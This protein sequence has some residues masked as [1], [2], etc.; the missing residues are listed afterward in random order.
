M[1]A[2]DKL[3]P[4]DK[5]E[6]YLHREIPTPG[7][8]VNRECHH[9]RRWPIGAKPVRRRGTSDVIQG[10]VSRSGWVLAIRPSVA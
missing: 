6:R 1:R 8:V 2:A 10:N 9:R 5:L 4:S 7:A 3:E